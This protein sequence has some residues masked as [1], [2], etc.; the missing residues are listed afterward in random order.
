MVKETYAQVVK[1]LRESNTTKQ[2]KEIQDKGL[3]K[4][5]PK[6]KDKD[7]NT[8]EPIMKVAAYVDNIARKRAEVRN[9]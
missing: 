4:K 5:K 6:S 9:G 2:V 8:Y 7:N 1:M 3:L